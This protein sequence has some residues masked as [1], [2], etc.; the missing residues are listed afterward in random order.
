MWVLSNRRANDEMGQWLEDDEKRSEL[1]GGAGSILTRNTEKYL[2]QT[3]LDLQFGHSQRVGYELGY[4]I[5]RNFSQITRL[6]RSTPQHASLGVLRSPD[7][8]SV[9]VETGF[10]SNSEE[11]AKLSTASYR[12]RVAYMIY[13]GLVDYR[14]RNVNAD[15]NTIVKATPSYTT[16]EP[17]VMDSGLRHKVKSGESLDSLAKKY[18]IKI[19]EIM[20][21]N[22]LKRKDLRIG[23]ILKIPGQAKNNDKSEQKQKDAISELLNKQEKKNNKKAEN[24]K[25]KMEKVSD[26]PKYH[27]IQQDQTIYAVGRLYG[28]S[29]D[30]ILKLN[31]KLKDGKVFAGQ[32]IQ[33]RE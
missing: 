2:N 18:G 32:K 12:R 15:I 17:Q 16:S 4:T 30:K 25:N 23:E 19:A 7:I 21:L 14:R 8:P 5:L 20:E 10:L 11:E 6:S 1:L 33:I 31:P 24:N 29:P 27:I 22:E 28:I 13:Q 26:T 3:V 9:L